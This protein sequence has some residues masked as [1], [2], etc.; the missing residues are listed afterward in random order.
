MNG[1][2]RVP[3]AEITVTVS[4]SRTSRTSLPPHINTSQHMHIL[5]N[6]VYEFSIVLTGRICSTIRS[7][8]II[9]FIFM[10]FR[11]DSAVTRGELRS[12]SP[13]WSL[14]VKAGLIKKSNQRFNRK[15]LK[16]GRDWWRSF[17]HR[18]P[19]YSGN[20]VPFCS[21]KKHIKIHFFL[22]YLHLRELRTVRHLHS[23]L[24][25]LTFLV[26]G[27]RVLA[28]SA[29]RIWRLLC[30]EEGQTRHGETHPPLTGWFC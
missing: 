3:R 26:P 1:I 27:S 20:K 25:G 7:F 8:L 29:P 28:G 10:T 9:S 11:C 19:V 18:V 15:M 24:I 5:H 6:V 2:F 21:R 12:Q 16:K 14:M 23:F 4:P 17:F 22:L 13:S 30:H